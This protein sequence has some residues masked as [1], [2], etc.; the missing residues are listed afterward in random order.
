MSE[1]LTEC[2]NLWHTVPYNKVNLILRFS[3][4]LC[5]NEK[6]VLTNHKKKIVK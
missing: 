3:Y 2:P 1:L 4:S 5:E 6:N